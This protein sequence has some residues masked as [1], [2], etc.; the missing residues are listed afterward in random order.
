[1]MFGEAVLAFQPSILE[2]FQESLRFL[3]LQ[4]RTLCDV[5]VLAVACSGLQFALAAGDRAPF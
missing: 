1:M 3:D 2:P 5:T 4:L